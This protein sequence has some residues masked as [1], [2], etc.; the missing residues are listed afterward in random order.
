MAT[1]ADIYQQVWDVVVVG[2]GMVGA[3]A[4]LGLAKNGFSVLVLEQQAPNM[5]W[6]RQT[7]VGIRVS[8]LTRASENILRNLNVWSFIVQNRHHPFRSMHV[9]DAFSSAEVTF[10]AAEIGEANLG[11]II[12][13]DLIQSAL[14]QGFAREPNLAVSL[15]SKIID[16]QL[17]NADDAIAKLSLDNDKTL[18]ARLVIA[19]DGGRSQIRQ[20]ANIGLNR[21]DYDQ[22]AVVGIVKTE[23]PHQDTCWQRYTENG[24]FAYL[25]MGNNYSSIAWYLPIEKQQWALSLSD[26]EFAQALGKASDYRLG[27]VV[28]V[29]QRGA[30]PLI[31]QHSNHYVKHGLAL[32]GDA[33]H[34]IHPQAGQGVNLGLLDAAALV[35]V[36]SA[37]KQANRDFSTLACLRKYERWRRGDNALVQRSMEWFAWFYQDNALKNGVRQGVLPIVN[38]FKPG[39]NW[40]MEQALNGREALPSLA[41]LYAI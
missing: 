38:H 37:A 18:Q 28:E 4:A 11:Y 25:S 6:N 29:G 31:R 19:A 33:A 2:G 8:A 1:Q 5:D 26:A 20:L 24:P 15:G 17:P 36:L 14:W 41:Q 22:C 13:N 7:P 10:N 30:F 34:T 35:D 27:Q 40:L 21:Q 9:W 32:I 16:L 23:L 3:A 12:E 39:K